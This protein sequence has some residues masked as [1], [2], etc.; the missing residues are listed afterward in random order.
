MKNEEPTNLCTACKNILACF[1]AGIFEMET[2][3]K[4]DPWLLGDLV[5]QDRFVNEV[6]AG[7]CPRCGADNTAVALKFVNDN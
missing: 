6:M 1:D 2:C 7:S 5:E 4:Y 3:S